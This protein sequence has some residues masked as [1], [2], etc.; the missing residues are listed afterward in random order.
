MDGIF[1]EI[2]DFEWTKNHILYKVF[3]VRLVAQYKI[4]ANVKNT[5]NFSMK[6][7]YSKDQVYSI[8]QKCFISFYR[9]EISKY[10]SDM[11]N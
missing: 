10:L 8:V 2:G 4:S 5:L 9:L 7:V 11:S 3:L 6:Q 1:N